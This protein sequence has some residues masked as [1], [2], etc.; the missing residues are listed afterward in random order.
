[1]TGKHHIAPPLSFKMRSFKVFAQNGPK[2]FQIIS[3]QYYSHLI[4]DKTATQKVTQ[5]AEG[6]KTLCN[7]TTKASPYFFLLCLHILRKDR[8]LAMLVIRKQSKRETERERVNKMR[9]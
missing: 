5:D 2:T 3:V 6:I 4:K 8:V 7:V 1:M 9:M